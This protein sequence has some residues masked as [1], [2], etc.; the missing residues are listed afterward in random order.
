MNKFEAWIL[1]RIVKKEVWNSWGKRYQVS[2]LFSIVNEVCVDTF[3]EDSW[4]TLRGFLED[5]FTHS[6]NSIEE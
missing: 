5:Q 1:K 6:L 2:D 3:V 4:P